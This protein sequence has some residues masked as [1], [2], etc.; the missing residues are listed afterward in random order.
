MSEQGELPTI[1]AV[2]VGG[3]IGAAARWVLA[4]QLFPDL[5]DGFPWVI[6][7]VNVVGCFLIGLVS[8]R[9]P[10]GSLTWSFLATGVLGGFTTMSSF[11]VVL[12]DLANDGRTGTAIVYALATLA[13][14]FLALAAAEAIRGPIDD[15]AAGPE[16]I[17]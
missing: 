2:A 14:G 4:A 7:G 16:R 10:R 9:V 13:S 5:S 17:E 6:F 11:A 3:A 1:G 12:N 8:T 15:R